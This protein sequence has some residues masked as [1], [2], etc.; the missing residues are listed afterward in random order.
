MFI[1][2]GSGRVALGNLICWGRLPLCC[3]PP[4]FRQVT[5]A[6]SLSCPLVCSALSVRIFPGGHGGRRGGHLYRKQDCEFFP[7]FLL[8]ISCDFFL[9]LKQAMEKTVTCWVGCCGAVAGK[10][11]ESLVAAGGLLQRAG[12]KKRSVMAA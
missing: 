8:F 3:G 1:L 2:G 9:N 4:Q 10:G 6:H 11:E 12:P 7:N 5:G